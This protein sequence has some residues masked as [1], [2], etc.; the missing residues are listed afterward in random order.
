M[1]LGRGWKR[2]VLLVLLAALAAG[3]ALAVWA[4]FVEPG[5]LV[6]NRAEVRLAGLPPAL[7]G[8]KVAAISDIHAGSPHIGLEKLR[9][10]VE[11]SN[12]LQPDL[13]VLLGDFV[14]Q[15]VVGGEFIEPEATAESLRGLRAP[16]GV[17]AVLGNHD[18]WLDGGRVT[19][20]LAGAGI[21]VLENDA[22]RVE[23][24]GQ[25][26]WVA[27]LA[28]LW[29][30]QPDAAK[31][32]AAV[33]DD[34]PVLLLT[35]N[36]DVFPEVPARVALTLAGHTHGGQG[37]LPLVGRPVVPSK[38]GQRYAMGHV[39]EDGRH[40]F[41]SGGVGTSI[42]PVRFRVPPEIVLMTLRQR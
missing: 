16:L 6:V 28:D 19:R 7:R 10:L 41:V 24:G 17:F 39:V 21:N 8:L 22:A 30:R 13:V 4:F 33:N 20:A 11:E 9:L 26:L 25:G 1:R 42:V 5:R 34:A 32:L 27:G 18:W 36:P 29:T 38:F 15:D 40:L 23:R 12:R 14:I 37:C 2:R 35:H 3:V 31:A